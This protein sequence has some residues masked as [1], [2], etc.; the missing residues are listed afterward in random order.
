MTHFREVGMNISLQRR[1][2]GAFLDHF[3]VDAGALPA[4]PGAT[5]NRWVPLASALAVLA[6][7]LVAGLLMLVRPAPGTSEPPAIP[8]APIQDPTMQPVVQFDFKPGMLAVPGAAAWS[9]MQVS[10]QTLDPGKPFAT[11]VGFYLGGD[12]PLV[13]MVLN[14]KL[15]ITPD[16]PAYL[17][18][19][20]Q[21]PAHPQR[22][23]GGHALTLQPQDAIVYST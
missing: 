16:G 23:D 22:L 13:V 2:P 5:R 11:D 9:D 21:D 17:Y 19:A 1:N 3:A 7:V 15:E 14:G 20:G 4:L 10:V 8:A 6:L 12:G 18:R